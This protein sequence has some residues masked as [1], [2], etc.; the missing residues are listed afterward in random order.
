MLRLL[1][2]ALALAA[3]A[4]GQPLPKSTATP[5]C[6]TATVTSPKADSG[7]NFG[8]C[9]SLT[10][11]TITCAYDESFCK[12][13]TEDYLTAKDVIDAGEICTCEDI[14]DYPSNIGTCSSSGVYSPM[15]VASDCNGGATAVCTA[16]T[17][18]HFLMGDTASGA[19]QFTACD[20]KCD[21]TKGHTVKVP[22]DTFQGCEFHPVD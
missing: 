6:T 19:A 14:L 9:K 16:N 17:D 2:L 21:H 7:C 10:S 1:L 3:P 5:V 11:N 20:L 18:G 22:T 4:A 12:A 13:A 15:A 8:A